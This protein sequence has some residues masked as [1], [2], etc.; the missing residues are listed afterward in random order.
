M[1]NTWLGRV[2]TINNNTLST[3]IEHRSK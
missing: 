3:A 1:Q 2:R